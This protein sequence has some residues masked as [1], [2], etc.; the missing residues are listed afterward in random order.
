MSLFKHSPTTAI[1]ES[2]LS[3]WRVSALLFMPVILL[4]ASLAFIGFRNAPVTHRQNEQAGTTLKQMRPTNVSVLTYKN[5]TW[6]TGQNAQE[7]LLTIHTVNAR[8]FGKRAS[9]PV[10]GRVYAQPLFVPHLR[11]HSA[12]YNA[13]FVATEHDSVYAFDADQVGDPRPLWKTSFLSPPDVVPVSGNDIYCA[14]IGGPDVG[15]TGT[16]VIDLKTETL[17]VVAVTKEHRQFFSRLHA[18][19]ITTG[20]EHPHSPATITATFPGTGESSV[21]GEIHFNPLRENQRVA[22]LLLHDVVYIAWGSH[23]DIP[24]Y[25]GWLMGYDASTLQQV[26]VYVPT[27]G[28]Q[29][30]G[31]WQG[32]AGLA[33]DTEGNIYLETGEGDFNLDVGEHEAGDTVLKLSTQRGLR[34]VDYFSPFN[35]CCLGQTNMD[36][37]SAGPLLLPDA[38]EVIATG[39]EGRIYVLDR[40]HLG[41]YHT[42]AAACS[43]LSRT[44]VDQVR[45]E[46]PP[47][48][49]VGGVFGSPA[50]WHGPSGDYVYVSGALSNQLKAFQLT[51]GLLSRTSS[52]QSPLMI[53]PRGGLLHV[54]GNPVVSC[55]GQQPGTAIVWLIDYHGLLRAYD[56][57]NLA[58]ELYTSMQNAR[59]DILGRAM[60][61]SVPTVANGEVFV[62]TTTSLVIYGLLGS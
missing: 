47:R 20:K 23:C 12:L 50:Y 7:S 35:Q 16:P 28:Q 54:A 48:T 21:H 2:L 6:R 26:D 34:V 41:G 14:N 57:A 56:A 44:D 25:Y 3:R 38:P 55:N 52:S 39:K 32:G 8:S 59:R 61:F 51:N 53:G 46:F 4:L 1:P 22:L 42:I 49:A 9:Y 45:Q 29:G 60:K 33:A 5:D 15:I 58:H 62:G 40:H 37:G 19:D 18:L 30:G 10:D 24:P 36:L 31:I 43:Q 17:Y 27:P 13:V 11:M